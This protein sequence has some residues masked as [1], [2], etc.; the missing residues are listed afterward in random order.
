MN[1]Y[2]ILAEGQVVRNGRK[3]ELTLRYMRAGVAKSCVFVYPES[4]DN[5][6]DPR[7]VLENLLSQGK[8]PTGPFTYDEKGGSWSE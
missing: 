1:D 5:P 3:I 4:L 2:E 8:N 6:P 7:A